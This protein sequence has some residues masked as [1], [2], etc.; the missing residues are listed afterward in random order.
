[1][2]K[3]VVIIYCGEPFESFILFLFCVLSF[4]GMGMLNFYICCQTP[5]KKFAFEDNDHNFSKN[6]KTK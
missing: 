1:M 4:T 3:I 5:P 2:K 6:K